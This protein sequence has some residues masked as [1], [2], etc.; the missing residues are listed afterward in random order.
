VPFETPR[1][2][3]SALVLYFALLVTRAGFAA[4]E[5]ERDGGARALVVLIGEAAKSD[6]LTAVLSELLGREQ[7]ALEFERKSRFRP[8]AILASSGGDA[9]V[10]VFISSTQRVAK[11]YF[12]GPFGNRFLLRKLELQRG[13]D[14]VGRELIAQ[15][16]DTSVLTLLRS[17][18]G[19]SREQVRADLADTSEPRDENSSEEALPAADENA[20]VI[21][22]PSTP[23]AEE[24]PV[25]SARSVLELELAARGVIK[26]TGSDLGVD[27]GIGGETGL[28][29]HLET[30]VFL[31]AR[32]VFEHGF[33]QGITT[34]VLTATI[35]ATAL[36]GG[37]DFGSRFGPS[38]LAVGVGFGA[39]LVRIDPETSFDPAV[40]L[41]EESSSTLAVVRLEARYELSA[42]IFQMAAGVFA[43]VPL[44]D[45]HYDVRGS[46]GQERIAE[47]WAVRPGALLT[48]GFSFNL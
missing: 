48:L 30:G 11:L 24:P 14:E 43:D 10:W 4:P 13:L 46:G 47:P 20:P 35:R 19:L 32:L 34:P 40:V 28:S 2:L 7:V 45:T 38:A 22:Q 31:R 37:I 39:D 6:E 36:R 27:H 23:P 9:R 12:R 8:S 17:E 42:G 44:A 33:G 41:A 15:V 25:E 26:W 29:Y 1:F 21:E 5:Q 18:A 16:V 3:L